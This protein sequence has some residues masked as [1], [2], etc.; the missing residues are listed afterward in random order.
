MVSFII[1]HLAFAYAVVSSVAMAVP[2]FAIGVIAVV[3]ADRSDLPAVV[4][5]LSRCFPH[6]PP[7]TARPAKA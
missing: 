1:A 5:A 4:D 7:V 2:I 3:R 6:R